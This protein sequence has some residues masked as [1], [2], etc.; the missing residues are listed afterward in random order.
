MTEVVTGEAVV[1]DLAVA[2]FPSRMIALLLDMIVELPVFI[3]VEW[4]AF[5]T[6][7][8]HLNTASA[9][10]L[11]TA[12][13]VLVFVGYPTTFETLTRGKTLGKMALGLRVV[14]DDGGPIR[15]R[16]ALIRGLMA[17]FVEV[18]NPL[19]CWVG[20]ITAMVSAKG[21]RLGD[22]AAGT[23]V[24]SERFPQRQDLP[25]SLAVI[26]PPLVGWAQNVE[27]SR[28][29]DHTAAA[30][31]S[32]LRRFHDLRPAARDALGLQLATSVAAQVSPPPPPGTPP[33]AYLS[34]VL[35]VR[36]DRE[37]AR[38][39]AQQARQVGAFY[40]PG[41]LPMPPGML[42]TPPGTL[43]M[44]PGTLPMPGGTLPM[45]PGTLPMPPGTLPMPPGTLPMPAGTLPMPPPGPLSMPPGPFR[46]PPRPLPTPGI[47]GG[48]PPV[49]GPAYLPG[50]LPPLPADAADGSGARVSGAADQLTAQPTASGQHPASGRPTAYEQPTASGQPETTPPAAS[51][52]EDHGFAVPR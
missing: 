27:L 28:L 51:Q 45:P 14:S 12:G 29:S 48:G 3:F 52:P 11:V 25:A 46:M 30:A 47:I 37:H 36:R 8:Q 22:L 21:K 34:A 44:P 42:P 19:F 1:L 24:I 4:V 6:S 39:A 9:A 31:S 49:V 23:F 10:A 32:Y 15:F 33:A 16:Q 43:P 20:L 26:P 50:M 17:A 2:R 41:M 5:I 35:A 18:W 40:P 13:Y 38:L 7:A